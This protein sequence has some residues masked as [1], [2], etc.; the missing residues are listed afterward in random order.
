MNQRQLLF[1]Q[2][3]LAG[4]SATEAAR[5]AGYRESTAKKAATR[6]LVLPDIKAAIRESRIQIQDQTQF[7][8]IEAMKEAQGAANFAIEHRNP[9]AYVKATEL[10][11]RLSGLL[12]ERHEILPSFD[13]AAIIAEARARVARVIDAPLPALPVSKTET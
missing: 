4:K 3:Y 10:R 2:A 1:T 12:V 5:Q 7:G 6:L 11:A 13:L 8:V 9:M